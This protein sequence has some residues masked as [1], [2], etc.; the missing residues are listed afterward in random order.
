MVFTTSAGRYLF[1]LL[2]FLCYGNGYSQVYNSLVMT[3]IMADPTPV[4]GL[5]AVEYLELYNRAG[6]P[7][8]LK[9]W[10][11]VLGTRSAT[12]PDTVI[13]PDEYVLICNKTSEAALQAFGKIIPLSTFSLSNDGSTVSLYQPTGQLVFS[14]TYEAAW[15]PA[16]KRDGGYSIEM[17]DIN[18]PCGEQNNWQV[19]EDKRGGTPAME[20]SVHGNNPDSEPPVVERVDIE[21]SAELKL[22]ANKRL[23]S[24][25]A[26]SGAIIE[27][28]GR[29]ILKRKLESPQFCTLILTLDSPLLNN[30]EYSL[31]IKN[32]S[33]CSGN[34]LRQANLSV[35]LPSKPDSGDVVLNEIL[36][37]PPE[38]GVD[39][40]EIY[41]RSAKYI[42]LK[43]WSLANVKN[44]EPD[45][46]RIL[47]T[48]DFI[49]PPH[50]Y[51]ALT[52]SPDIVKKLYPT[53]KPG[54]FLRLSSLPAYSNAEGGVVLANE[55]KQVYDRFDYN[56][57]MHDPLIHDTKGVSLEKADVNLSSKIISNW[58]SA[59]STTGNATPGYANSQIKTEVDKDIFGIEPEAFMLGSNGANDSARIKYKLSQ[60]GKIA[61][62][63]IFDTN[64][65]LV[66]NL[67]RNQLIGTDGEISWDGRNENG[68]IVPTGYYLVLID[69]FD[70]GGNTAQYKRKVVVVKN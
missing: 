56:E 11:L 1:T 63:Q 33:D 61:T 30:E 55:N 4:A 12:F 35:G 37:N 59:A 49:L 7:I 8:L 41:N 43:N 15:W 20:N 28:T 70:S 50:H 27:L 16:G 53:E 52:T 25:N 62:I 18:N 32:L 13:Q 29:K 42:A 2:F 46:F 9:N 24:L 31:S 23:D 60:P 36:F 45:V 47:S 38:G 48:D 39:F 34:L 22:V 69:L 5:P 51:L 40:V 21:A 26:V 58:H 57:D 65:R 14:V 3:E 17:I 66:K 6:H 19:S 68:D 64:G 44:G 10:K 67:L 54:H